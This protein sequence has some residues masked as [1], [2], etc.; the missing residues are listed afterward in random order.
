MHNRETCT[1]LMAVPSLDE[2]KEAEFVWDRGLLFSERASRAL[3]FMRTATE[4][5]GN[6]S[7]PLWPVVPGSLHG[8]F[9]A[10]EDRDARFLVIA[11]DASMHGRAEVLRTAPD[12]PCVEVVGCYWTVVDL[13]G[14][15]FI[16]PAALPD[17]PAAQVYR[18]TTS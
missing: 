13:L 17:C 14:S 12:K 8:A 2:E 7:Q 10:G 16:S 6:V 4:K 1:G 5:H 15:A 9:L 11:F 3:E 18:A